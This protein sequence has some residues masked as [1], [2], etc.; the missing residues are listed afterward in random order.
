MTCPECGWL[1]FRHHPSGG[2]VV[3][4]ICGLCDVIVTVAE[5]D[6]ADA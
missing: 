3:E 5:V 6:R 1:D 4:I 2:K